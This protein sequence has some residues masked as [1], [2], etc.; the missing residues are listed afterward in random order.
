MSAISK[1]QWT[2]ATWNPVTG[3]TR[4]SEG[5]THCYA[6]RDSARWSDAG[7]K[8]YSGVA[9]RTDSG[10]RWTGKVRLH[11]EVLAEPFRYKK[12]KRIFVCSMSDLFHPDV[13]FEFI[14]QVFA[15][16]ALCP[17]HTFQVLTKRPERMAQYTDAEVMWSADCIHEEVKELTGES[18]VVGEWPMPNV[19]LGTSC[20]DQA[21]ADQRIPHLLQCPA[22]VRFLSLEPLLGPIDLT[23]QLL[24]QHAQTVRRVQRG[25]MPWDAPAEQHPSIHWVIVGG[26]SGPGARPMHP[27]WARSIRDQCQAAGVPFFFKQW[28]EY[29]PGCAYYTEADRIREEHLDRQHVIVSSGGSVWNIDQDHQPPP[30]AW[31]MHCVGKKTAGRMLDGREWNQF[32]SEISNLKSAGSPS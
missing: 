2:D 24:M 11:P 26:E 19:W 16:M 21:T 15:V 8:K 10:P 1:I 23:P 12:P 32:P 29:E 4:V 31:F 18:Y 17:Q 25:Q 28:G 5:C 13:P 6:E 7:S 3:C 22:A 30:R 20:E 14:D 27:D 9:R